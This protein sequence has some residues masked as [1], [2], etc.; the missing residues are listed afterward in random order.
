MNFRDVEDF[1]KYDVVQVNLDSM[2]MHMIPKI[3]RM[4]GDSST[5][6]VANQDYSP[7]TWKNGIGLPWDAENCIRAA[8]HVFATTPE[9]HSCYNAWMP[10]LN[11]KMIPHPIETD[12]LKRMSTIH[13][14]EHILVAYHRYQSDTLIPWMA[15]QGLGLPV[16]LG[17]HME[18]HDDRK[19]FTR[20]TFD[21]IFPNLKFQDFVK[22]LAESRIVYD[23]M[24][25]NS[26]GRVPCDCAC[27]GTPAVC[28]NR[29]YS[30]RI[31]YPDTTFDPYDLVNVKKTLSR[32]INDKGF[33]EHVISQASYNVEYFNH[34]NSRERYMA[35]LE[36]GS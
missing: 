23:F 13:T 17:G 2:D 27:V 10:D 36:E 7:D 16:S 25:N 34:K 32:L 35:M 6:I 14:N 4:I 31:C 3:K 28:S 30:A 15:A 24:L 19:R 33:A 11:V 1:E 5:K 21:L 20:S 9:A 22:M 8:D 18:N 26:F 12:V 29:N